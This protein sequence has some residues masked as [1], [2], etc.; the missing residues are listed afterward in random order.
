ME[1][2]QINY[3]N[4][5]FNT[6]KQDLINYLRS[7]YPDQWQDF[8]VASPGMALLELNAYVADLLS[9][10]I[11]KKFIE[12]YLDGAQSRE[13]VY[14]L[15][16]TK[17]Y[18]VPGVRPAL[19]IADIIIEVP[20]TAEGPNPEYLPIY[21]RGLQIKGAG[22][23]FETVNDIDFSSDF[24][25]EG[26]ENRIIEPILNGNQEL[27]RYRIV[28]REK[29]Q[30]GITLIYK[31]VVADEGGVP[32]FKIELPEKNVLDIV[33]IVIKPGTDQSEPPSYNEFHDDTYK[34]YEVDF[35]PT[36]K[37]FVEDD[38][39]SEVNGIK[40][41]YWKS[42]PKRFEKEF[43]ADGTCVI[44][45]GG[46]S[47]D[48]DAYSDYISSLTE[49][50]LCRDDINLTIAD[51]L[52]NTALG[53]KVAKNSTIWVQYRVGGGLLSNVGANVLNV[54]SNVN[55]VITGTDAAINSQVVSSTRGNNPI[56]ALGG[57]GLPSIEE[58]RYNIAANH[59]AQYRCVT[60][61][62]YISRAYQLPGKFGGPFRLHAKV[63]ENKVQ[64]FILTRGGDG[65]LIASSTSIIKENLV[66]YM[67][68]YRMINDFV[69]IND[70]KIINLAV[71]IDLFID[72]NGFNP[73]EIK[74]NAATIAADFFDVDKWQ[75]NQ[76]IYVSQLV[77]S[78]R[79]IPGVINIVN[80]EFYN[81]QGGGYSDTLISQ[82]VGETIQI[83]ETG[84]FKTKIEL[85]DNAIFST[86]ISMFE[87]RNPNKDIR[88][89]V[90]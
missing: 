13:S 30:A 32:F 56:P 85:I 87:I 7:F 65:K 18:K 74:M 24:S 5:D 64:F 61:P 39:Y 19:T 77:D 48:Y 43:K 36:N 44:T 90:S 84:G 88:I 3:L 78:L 42:V 27:L 52:D 57:K 47:E 1:R 16:K 46:G 55:P 6:V 26:D 70:G 75:M 67:T 20:A 25:E 66:Q 53:T 33:T 68:A 45:F 2:V 58:I 89:R 15:A 4:R 60:L 41:G 79:E 59:A 22:Q 62:D 76:H 10:I 83:P 35:L 63:D 38:S 14:R 9:N 23:V 69:E 37:I 86:P 31:T 54:V 81:M 34:Y 12:L 8:N 49:L 17:G 21:R 72:R 71:D 73:R 80:I 29:V 11:D 40:V 50:D 82:A 51:I 28:K